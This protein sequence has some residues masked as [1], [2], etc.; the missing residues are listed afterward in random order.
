MTKKIFDIVILTE[1]RYI[2]PDI[3]NWY[4]NQVL[5]EDQILQE[6]LENIGI[7]VCRKD[8]ADQNFD[9]S[10]TK[11]VIFRTTW[12]YF[13]RFDEFFS[14]IN[15]TKAKTNFINSIDIIYWNIDKHYLRELSQKGINITPSLFIKKDQRI[16]LKHLLKKTKWMEAV[17]KPTI[18]GAARHTYRVNIN[19]YKKY[20][21]LFQD[22]IRNECMIFQEFMCNIT[23]KGE[24]SLIMIGGEYTHAVRKIAKKGDF[25]VQDDHGGKVISYEAN[26]MEIEFAKECIA[27]CPFN[28]IYARV[29]IIY[30]NKYE[31]A[32]VELELIEPELWFRN[33][34]KSALLL[35]KEISRITSS[36]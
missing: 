18:S 24:I 20:E 3:K 12:D 15:Q 9:W 10:S 26:S 32:L 6:K 13:D 35:A 33:N 36:K 2:D 25:R 31:L 34:T 4:I 5:L 30:D 14:W 19:N 11:Y 23:L 1:N 8:W 21:N 7:K 16:S 27:K 28:P 17:I 22:L 29:D